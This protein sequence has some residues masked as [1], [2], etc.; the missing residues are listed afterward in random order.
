MAAIG[1]VTIELRIFEDFPFL[2]FAAQPKAI[3]N[4]HKTKESTKEPRTWVDASG[5]CTQVS[6]ILR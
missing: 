4:G 2:L 5:I 3:P 1:H 6:T